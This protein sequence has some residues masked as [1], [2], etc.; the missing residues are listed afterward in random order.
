[1]PRSLPRLP[2]FLLG[3]VAATLLV[4][5]SATATTALKAAAAEAPAAS[6]MQASGA[7]Q[8]AWS[9]MPVITNIGEERSNFAYA[10]EP[11]AVVEDAVLVRNS[12]AT[13]LDLAVYGSDAFTDESGALDI[14]TA[15]TGSDA[16]GTWIAP[17]VT[18]VHI[19]PGEVTR[20]PF[21]VAVPADA[22]PGEQAGAL[23]TVLQSAGDTVSV[24][25]RYATRVTV[26]VSGDLTAGL[27][28]D[29]AQLK[30][31][32]GFWPWE[33]AS[34]D[35]SY[36]VANTGNTRLTAMQLI[37]APGVE[38]YSSPDASTGLL[39][40]AELLPAAAVDVAA[41][42]EG[43]SAWLPFT[44]VEVAVSPTV[45]TTVS[46]EIPTIAQ[47][48]LS[49]STVAIAPGWWVLLAGVALAL[50]VAVRFAVR[51]RVTRPRMPQ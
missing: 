29:Q 46:G 27:S 11:G 10:L 5:L 35:V 24:D 8:V 16:I 6:P 28:L 40:L 48:Q 7:G 33:A 36:T 38:L 1:M 47:Q 22:Q 4:V 14:A 51:R 39:T 2:R 32:T 30:V 41:T 26:T 45:I 31:T 12:G 37:T 34:A 13:V 49:L 18:S 3:V 9:M 19:E 25:M 23:L 21:S 17:S 43:L 50:V 15:E 44:A 20:I 42:V